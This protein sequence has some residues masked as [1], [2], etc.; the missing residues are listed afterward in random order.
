LVLLMAAMPALLHAYTVAISSTTKSLYLQ[1]GQGTITGGTTVAGG[2][3][4]ANNSTVNRVSV[5]VPAASLGTG[6]LP[7]TPNVAVPNSYIDGAS[8]C[9]GTDTYVGGMYRGPNSTASSA[10]LTAATPAGGLVNGAGDTIS[11][12]TISWQ[13]QTR[14]GDTTGNTLASSTF[15]GN[16]STQSVWSIA[17]NS[18][19]ESC[20]QFNYGNTQVPPAGTYNGRV[21]YTL[22]AP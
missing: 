15:T 21:V 9:S 16:G 4:P 6:V 7:M 22:S 12:N 18:W 17:R 20:L 10:T 2:A 14:S 3:T 19:A 5:T 1:V 11:F 8:Y 13:T